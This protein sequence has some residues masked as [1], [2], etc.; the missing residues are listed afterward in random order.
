MRNRERK[1]LKPT[2]KEE[3]VLLHMLPVSS[4]IQISYVNSFNHFDP[5]PV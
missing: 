1:K 3:I 5:F 4:Y 2:R